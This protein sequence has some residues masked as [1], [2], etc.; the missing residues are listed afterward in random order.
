MILKELTLTN[1]GPY[2]GKQSF[3]L[4]PK[5]R[6]RPLILVG[7]MNGGGKTTLLDS[8]HLVLY[9]KRA[10]LSNKKSKTWEKYLAACI[11]RSANKSV[12]AGVELVFDHV[13][14]GKKTK[15]TITRTWKQKD[16]TVKDDLAVS[17]NDEYNE[18]WTENWGEEVENLFPLAIAPLFFFD[19][20]KIEALAEPGTAKDILRTAIWALLGL[21]LIDRLKAD[22]VHFERK[23]RVE[24]LTEKDKAEANSRIA[25]KERFEEQKLSLLQKKAG[26]QSEFDQADANLVRAEKNFQSEGGN[27]YER[28]LELE[29]EKGVIL[30]NLGAQEALLRQ[31]ASG[32]L[33]LML[34]NNQLKALAKNVGDEA[35]SSHLHSVAPLIE[36]AHQAA[37]AKM[38][39]E[40]LEAQWIKRASVILA[41]EL[42]VLRKR[43]KEKQASIGLSRNAEALLGALVD[44]QE[45]KEN[46]RRISDLVSQWEGLAAKLHQ[47]DRQLK[48][49]PDEEKIAG[50]REELLAAKEDRI[51]YQALLKAVDEQIR[52]IDF[53]ILK[54]SREI[55]KI[56]EKHA[57]ARLAEDEQTRI[58]EHSSKVKEVLAS[59]E[60]KVL[61]KHL[62]EIENEILKCFNKLMRKDLLVKRIGIDPTTFETR[63]FDRRDEELD[64][65]RLSAG[66]R[67]L[68]AV[69][70][71]WGLAKVSGRT[72]PTVVDTPMGRLDS[73]HREKMVK[74]Y[75][76]VAGGQVMLLSQDEEVDKDVYPLL[77]D[78]VSHEYELDHDDEKEVTT[79]RNGYPFKRRK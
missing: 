79:I 11:H 39:N 71:L 28:R 24:T 56:T 73:V 26:L 34:L 13:K 31:E 30:A 62:R 52:A 49:V 40:G 33:P 35:G 9:G 5:D 12:G 57:G 38:K 25:E 66:E 8:L 18:E 54:V 55:E 78:F 36:G 19:G 37:I 74:N 2:A 60:E 22:L 16:G 27:L 7:S 47:A 32:M 77:A 21:D 64:P 42:E 69:A 17:L 10:T 44:G 50:Q 29:S 61:G 72:L 41:G 23:Q 46:K 48:S 68:F 3:D 70:V 4:Q 65:D 63:L 51:K 59:F 6:R 67:Q 43:S 15:Y 45:L 58:M 14:D 75:Y 20:E 1:F 76:P 53:E